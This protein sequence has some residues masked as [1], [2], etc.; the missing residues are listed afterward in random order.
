MLMLEKYL[1]RIEFSSYEEFVKD[2]TIKVPAV[3]NF[4]YDVVDEWA[5]IAPQKTALVWC[6]EEGRKA[7]FT[8]AD[9]KRESDKAANFFKGLGIGKG[10]PVMLI[11]KRRYEF[12]FSL[13]ALHKLGAVAIPATHLLTAKDIIYRNNAAGIKAIVA[14]ADPRAF[15][16]L[17]ED[18]DQAIYSHR[19]YP[20]RT[21]LGTTWLVSALNRYGCL[22]TRNYQ[23]GVFPAA[24]EVSGEKLASDYNRK[25]KGCFSCTIPCSR[26]FRLDA[27]PFGGLAS[28]GPEFEGL[29]GFSSRVG[30]SDVALA[31]KAVDM[32]NRYGLDVIT[33]SACISFAMECY[34][35]GI[36]GREEADGLDLSWGH[37]PTILALIGK[38][39]RREGFG[40][41]LADGTPAA[42]RQIGRGSEKYVMD[43]KGLEFFQA[44][45]RG[46]KAYGLGVAV[47]SRGGDHCRCEPSFEFSEDAEEGMRRYGIADS[48]FR[49][50][51]RGKGLVVKDFEEKCVLADALNACKNTIVNMEVLPYDLAA[52]FLNAAVGW[53]MSADEVQRACERVVNLERAFIAREGI[54]REDDYLP[55]RFLKEPLPPDSGPSAGQVIEL[56]PMLDEYYAARGWELRTGLPT[57]EKLRS[58]GL[59]DVADDLIADS[60][61]A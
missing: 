32:C 26:F 54:R 3:F 33:T 7:R 39:A 42:A 24:A 9:L 6:D 15:L 60:I 38:I 12:W 49:L 57:T 20:M 53:E 19:D 18:L 8:F 2:F 47:A 28:E 4:A 44:D 31:L 35:K 59:G 22:A 61:Q 25:M 21:R 11:L 51:Y 56:E 1:P 17:I 23:T 50:A 46:I 30:N 43:V 48:A 58:L 10:D 5:R 41:V 16:S 27:D 37:G 45:P 13:L 14:V 34:E 40:D 36:I 55:E 52:R 29:A